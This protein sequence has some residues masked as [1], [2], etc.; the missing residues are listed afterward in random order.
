MAPITAIICGDKVVEHRRPAGVTGMS[1]YDEMAEL[2]AR[3]TRKDGV[4][5]TPITRVHLIR[6]AA[7]RAASRAASAGFALWRRAQAGEFGTES[8]RLRPV[9][10]SVAVDLPVVAWILDASEGRP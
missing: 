2:I 6:L 1:P 9:A 3:N 5:P 10:I 7:D 4:H 8:V